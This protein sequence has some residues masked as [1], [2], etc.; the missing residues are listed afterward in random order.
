M[1]LIIGIMDNRMKNFIKVNNFDSKIIVINKMCNIK[2]IKDEVDVIIPFGFVN[3][4]GIIS[5]TSVHIYELIMTLKVNKILYGNISNKIILDKISNDY[6]IPVDYISL[7][8]KTK[9]QIL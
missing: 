1:K 4:Y 5:N 7:K 2:T 3:E 9:R 8:N 6:S